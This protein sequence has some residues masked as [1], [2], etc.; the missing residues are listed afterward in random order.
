MIHRPPRVILLINTD[1]A[2]ERGLMHG[3]ARYACIHG[4]WEFYRQTPFYRQSQEG[5]NILARI[6]NWKAD[7]VIMRENKLM[8]DI[9][10]LGLPTIVSPFSTTDINAHLVLAENES[11]GYEGAKHLLSKGFQYFGFCGFDDQYWSMERGK[12]F[13][14]K[15][16]TAGKTWSWYQSPISLK[17]RLWENEPFHMAKWLKTLEKPVAIM[18]ATDERAQQ[19]MEATRIAGFSVPEE[20]SILGVDNDELICEL[21]APSLSSV[22]INPEHGGYSAADL[23]HQSMQGNKIAKRNKCIRPRYVVTRHSTDIF[24]VPDQQLQ[25]A[26]HFINN[27]THQRLTVDQV[28]A[29]TTI[30]RRRLEERFRQ[31]LHKSV[32][33][34]IKRNKIERIKRMLSQ[35][36]LSISEIAFEL[37]FQSIQNV[38][39]YFK[40][41]TGLTPQQYRKQIR[42]I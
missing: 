26:L 5:E 16:T 23:L 24:A 13:T 17:D 2:F 36:S 40:T 31:Y 22:D 30:S 14:E 25:K 19:I 37:G 39:R 3:I 6:K 18:A 8:K 32:L 35:T 41:E 12:A 28:V 38:S 27:H 34:E 7:G 9:L 4:P 21:S 42:S 20:I 15:I 33:A 29:A 1:R 11:I 10:A